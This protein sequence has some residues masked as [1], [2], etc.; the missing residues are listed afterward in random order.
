MKKILCFIF[1]SAFLF[2]TAPVL[3]AYKTHLP[4]AHNNTTVADK[5]QKYVPFVAAVLA[6][7]LKKIKQ[8][9]GDGADVNWTINGGMT[10]LMFAA[11]R[12]SFET[13]KLLI[14]KGADVN[15]VNTYFYNGPR[16][17]CFQPWVKNDYH[18]G[19]NKT[20]LFYALNNPDLKVTEL[21]LDKGANINAK[22]I[23]GETVL[24]YAIDD[25]NRPQ[26]IKLLIAKGANIN[27]KDI[28]G[29][30]Q[31]IKLLIDRGANVNA[32]NNFNVTVLMKALHKGDLQ[33]VKLL[34]DKGASINNADNSLLASAIF[35][36]N[37]DVINFILSKGVNINETNK[38]GETAL[39]DA[40]KMGYT[41]IVKLLIEKGANI[42][43]VNAENKNA[44]LFAVEA[45]N[46][47]ILE[48]FNGSTQQEYDEF[49]RQTMDKINAQ[50]FE[51]SKIL[52]S[53]GININ[54]TDNNGENVLFYAS[55]NKR[56][57][58]FLQYFIIDKK[59]NA[60]VK[61]KYNQTPLMVAIQGNNTKAVEILTENISDATIKDNYGMTIL[62]YAVKRADLAAVKSLL[63]K[64]I[65][66]DQKNNEGKTALMF[67]ADYP[68]FKKEQIEIVNM[69]ISKGADVNAKDND[70]RTPLMFALK[71]A[72][73]Q[74]AKLLLNKQIN[75]NDA[76]ESGKTALMYTTLQKIIYNYDSSEIINIIISKGADV[77]AKDND[78]RTPLML[79]LENANWETAKILLNEKININ[80]KDDEGKTALMFASSH[81]LLSDE[82]IAV[83]NS[84]IAKGAN[85]NET[86]NNGNTA[87]TYAKGKS[88][89]EI[90]KILS[91]NGAK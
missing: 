30:P 75:I 91:D 50:K 31:M 72:N 55:R 7:D 14:E 35:S 80:E 48:G 19:H 20:A 37:T 6:N 77:N 86:D 57:F 63:N 61:N 70:R 44:L 45:F 87:L 62:M 79:A 23:S 84:I 46:N 34:T 9:I 68:S 41:E 28:K 2:A 4:V 53:N 26:I 65:I 89:P 66:I 38:Y 22:D 74:I 36:E 17:K 82:R 18:D 21:L 90:I 10:V 83:I 1:V 54:L 39:M 15:A 5:D 59:M 51:T 58:V 71:R 52:I 47:P 81:F 69:I 40:S 64:E 76:D 11:E 29:S 33:T 13:V 24:M 85:V 88:I 73:W 12:S 27:A 49:Y 16:V 60:T 67:A 25:K 8:L 3:Q 56:G 78:G 32:K 43:A 42:N